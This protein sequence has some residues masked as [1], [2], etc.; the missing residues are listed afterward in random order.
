MHELQDINQNL[1]ANFLEH[2]S[3]ILENKNYILLT[4]AV[5]YAVYQEL[6]NTP[7]YVISSIITKMAKTIATLSN[8]KIENFK[9]EKEAQEFFKIYYAEQLNIAD[10]NLY[11]QE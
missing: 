3:K 7:K 9:S 5:E 11:S 1:I 10:K 8:R 4:K 6:P 2:L